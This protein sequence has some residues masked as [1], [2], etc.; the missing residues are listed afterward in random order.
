M[1]LRTR[2]H[3]RE[4]AMNKTALGVKGLSE[5]SG[6]ETIRAAGAPSGCPESLDNRLKEGRLN[7]QQIYITPAISQ[8]TLHQCRRGARHPVAP[9][10]RKTQNRVYCF[11][12]LRWTACLLPPQATRDGFPGEAGLP[13]FPDQRS[14]GAPVFFLQLSD[15]LQS[16]PS[17]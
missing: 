10:F 12:Y 9:A 7:L 4:G 2:R 3:E 6:G 17:S 15:R 8:R 11:L 5:L 14:F 13:G 16:F 1:T